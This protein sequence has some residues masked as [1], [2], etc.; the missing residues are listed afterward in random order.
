MSPSALLEMLAKP[1]VPEWLTL[2]IEGDAPLP[3]QVFEA[4]HLALR[5]SGMAKNGYGIVVGFGHDGRYV[6]A[7]WKTPP[8]QWG[9]SQRIEWCQRQGV[10]LI[11]AVG[12]EKEKRNV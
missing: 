4:S 12:F 5:D 8:W 11:G 9:Q 10:R 6:I 2:D 1:D 7:F 3:N